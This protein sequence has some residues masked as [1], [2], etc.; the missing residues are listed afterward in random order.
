MTRPRLLVLDE[1]TAGLSPK[2][3]H[4]L[5]HT[6]VDRLAKTGI[7]ILLV[8]QHAREA[9]AI[10]DWAYVLVSGEVHL[11]ESAQDLLARPDIG[12]IFLGRATE[13]PST[14]PEPAVTAD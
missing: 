9:L 5:L 6:H 4:E 12:E 10:S 8:E 11:S 7:A 14:E 13:P 3:A 2:L 1:P